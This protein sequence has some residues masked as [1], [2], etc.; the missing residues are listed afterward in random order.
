MDRHQVD[1]EVTVNK[2]LYSKK[3][4]YILAALLLVTFFLPDIIG[5]IPAIILGGMVIGFAL[6]VYN[7][8]SQVPG[9][10]DRHKDPDSDQ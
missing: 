1:H 5:P 7:K 9:N 10:D 2:F 3:L 4:L 6:F 8:W